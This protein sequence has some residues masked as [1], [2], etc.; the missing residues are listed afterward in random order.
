[1]V[2][3]LSSCWEKEKQPT[4]NR[5]NVYGSWELSYIELHEE[6]EKDS[7]PTGKVKKIAGKNIRLNLTQES[8]QQQAN[9]PWGY[10]LNGTTRANLYFSRY[11]I[12]GSPIVPG[13]DPAS[14]V[15][16]IGPIGSTKVGASLE[17]MELEHLYYQALENAYLCD[18][19]KDNQLIIWSK[20]QSAK[21]VFKP[22]N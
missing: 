9:E 12:T 17:E 6:G 14:H 20:Y 21:L 13:D 11:S 22:I 2:G 18:I 4:P 15:V 8:A 19:S 16:K 3:M 1:M 5:T 10:K 7:Q